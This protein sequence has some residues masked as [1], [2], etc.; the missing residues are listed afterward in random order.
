MLLVNLLVLEVVG[1]FSSCQIFDWYRELPLSDLVTGVINLLITGN[2]NLKGCRIKFL[3]KKFGHV[4]SGCT[5]ISSPIIF[6]PFVLRGKLI[7]FKAFKINF[8]F[9]K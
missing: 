2:L 8:Y 5:A 9:V 4:T 6:N 3:V 1:E 7:V